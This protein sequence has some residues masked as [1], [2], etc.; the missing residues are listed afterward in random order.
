MKRTLEMRSLS[1]FISLVFSVFLLSC[2]SSEAEDARQ[3]LGDTLW[4]YDTV[5]ICTERK[6][7]E[8]LEDAARIFAN[9]VGSLSDPKRALIYFPMAASNA[10]YH[11]NELL[12]TCL[13]KIHS[14]EL[15]KGNPDGMDFFQ[16]MEGDISIVHVYLHLLNVIGTTH[17]S[18]TH[19]VFEW[20]GNQSFYGYSLGLE[21]ALRSCGSKDSPTTTTSSSHAASSSLSFVKM[22]TVK[23]FEPNAELDG[24][25]D[26]IIRCIEHFYNFTLKMTIGNEQKMGLDSIAFKGAIWASLYQ[27]EE[28]LVHSIIFALKSL[29]GQG[30][31]PL[32]GCTCH[33][34]SVLESVALVNI[35]KA[36][37]GKTDW[38]FESI[39]ALIEENDLL[40]KDPRLASLASLKNNNLLLSTQQAL[41]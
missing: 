20:L 21:K 8:H 4:T 22:D 41:P 14:S 40:R 12:F 39:Q 11:L 13:L 31:K 33:D 24:P 25:T 9:Q 30:N 5:K 1:N 17:L 2:K 29:Y 35:S 7:P 32:A 23:V 18:N 3:P 10:D 28:M 15:G 37:D 26:E 36:A 27:Q 6:M 34:L 19:E 16:A 38:D